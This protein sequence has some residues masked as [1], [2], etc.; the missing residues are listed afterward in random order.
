MVKK[1]ITW[2][3]PTSQEAFTHTEVWKSENQ[4]VSWTEFAATNDPNYGTAGIVIANS[5]AVDLLGDS[6]HWYKIRFYDNVNTVW[7]D[8]SDVMTGS[9]FRGYCTIT[10]VR[11]FTNVQSGEYSDATIQT[12]IDMITKS[13]DTF[14]NRTWQGTITETDRYYDGNDSNFIILDENDLGSVSSLAIDEDGEGTYTAISSAYIHLYTDRAG[15][16][17]DDDAEVTK[18]PNRR[19]SV[20]I[21]YTYGNSSP[22]EDVRHLAILLVANMMKMDST[23]TAMIAEL[24]AGL[25][26]GTYENTPT[27][28]CPD[29]AY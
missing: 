21:T 27:G 3:A 25:I 17:L 1:Y 29:S 22:T 8:Y 16:L 2:V 4:G 20:K 12:M 18:F 13:T 24:K 9:D 5:Y 15:V 23:R 19:R 11:N 7:G 28:V 10:D 26:V 6:G 14:T